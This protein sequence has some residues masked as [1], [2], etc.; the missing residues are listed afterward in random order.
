MY[1]NRG[2][3]YARVERMNEKENLVTVK[4]DSSAIDRKREFRFV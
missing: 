2:P 3:A 4:R 1:G